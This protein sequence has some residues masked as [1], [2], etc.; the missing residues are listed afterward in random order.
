MSIF[1]DDAIQ[2][3]LDIRK[4]HGNLP[5][6][7]G[8]CNKMHKADWVETIGIEDLGEYFLEEAHQEDEETPFV[9]AV[10]IG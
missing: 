1:I 4:E 9:N 5:I 3:L 2:A 6:V 10:C 8:D 7:F